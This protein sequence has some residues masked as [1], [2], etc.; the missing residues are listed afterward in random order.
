MTRSFL[1]AEERQQRA[2]SVWD[3]VSVSRLNLWLRCPLAF[4]LKYI[5]GIDTPPSASQFIGRRVHSAL[6]HLY[7]QRM[8]G[9]E[10]MAD[11]IESHLRADWHAALES[12]G[13]PFGDLRTERSACQ[14]A[15]QLVAAYRQAEPIDDGASTAVESALRVPLIDPFSGT[16]LG[17]PLVGIIDLVLDGRD[18]PTIV[19]FKT[20]ARGGRPLTIM[21]ELQLSAYSYLL[22]QSSGQIERE[23]EIR[24]L[25]KTSQPR[26][27]RF[28]YA[29]RSEHQLR[30]LFAVI[31]AYLAALE[32][33]EFIFRPGLMCASC[34]F[35]D[36]ACE[37][38]A[39]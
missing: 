38:W 24:Q 26:L 23:L 22:R 4:K 19:D 11:V 30:R 32:R 21:H 12:E 39:A 20:A 3:Y 9:S 37:R 18:G 36:S 25:V 17:I 29:R 33:R 10:P 2:G 1:D 7:R 6:E 31:R 5:D 14:Q 28:C 16:D 8:V 13:N 34:E 27:E 15:V 35:L